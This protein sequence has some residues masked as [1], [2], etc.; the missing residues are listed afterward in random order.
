MIKPHLLI[1]EDEE[2][3]VKVMNY[4]LSHLGYE[5]T[6]ALDGEKGLQ[7]ALSGD[8]DA[9]LVDWMLPKRSGLDIITSLRAHQYKGIILL[10]TA[11]TDEMSA[12]EGLNAGADDFL[13]KPYYP[14]ELAT[15]LKRL[16]QHSHR[17]SISIIQRDDVT[18]QLLQH[19]VLVDG[20]PCALTKSE[21]DL[22]LL[23]FRNP[24]R[25]YSRDDLL[26]TLWGFEYDGSSRIIDV[27]ISKLRMKIQSRSGRITAIRGVGYRW[28]SESQKNE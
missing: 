14:R 28:E 12:V 4:D 18:V 24:N 8:F 13:R 23:L 11:K 10:I 15:R 20:N 22:F 19:Q 5:I 2:A 3:L 17:D 25:V 16:L 9:I 7:L 21:F 26:N 6:T 1:V 27:H